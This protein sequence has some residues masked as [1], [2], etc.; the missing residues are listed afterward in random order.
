MGQM[1]TRSSTSTKEKGKFKPSW[2]IQAE[3]E[4]KA[5]SDRAAL[6]AAIRDSEA[7]KLTSPKKDDV[8]EQLNLTDVVQKMMD[9]GDKEEETSVVICDADDAAQEKEGEDDEEAEERQ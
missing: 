7:N 4:A 1:R 6:R 5:R 8:Q 2:E 9:N 3:R